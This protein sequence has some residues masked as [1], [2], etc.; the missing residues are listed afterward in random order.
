MEEAGFVDAVEKRYEWPI[1]TWANREK[2]KTLGQWFRD[3]ILSG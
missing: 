1:R 2:A 3:D